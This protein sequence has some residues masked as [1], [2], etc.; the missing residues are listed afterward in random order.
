MNIKN[1]KGYFAIDASVAM[2]I[3]LMV[4]PLIAGMIYNITKANSSMARKT[5]AVNIAVNSIETIKGIGV[6]GLNDNTTMDANIKQVLKQVYDNLDENEMTLE[7]NDITYQIAYKITDYA[8]TEAGQSK[9]TTEGLVKII[10][11]T[12]QYRNQKAT[13]EVKLETAIS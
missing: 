6:T 2:I 12:V 7:K 4:I 3:L 9:L 5:E 1:N 13:K 8:S 10:E 11:V